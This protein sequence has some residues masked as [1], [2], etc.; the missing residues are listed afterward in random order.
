MP[1]VTTDVLSTPYQLKCAVTGTVNDEHKTTTYCLET[2]HPLTVEYAQ[3]K[4]TIQYPLKS[5][6]KD[7]LR[8][9]PTS[10]VY[11]ERLSGKYG[12]EIWAKLEFENP[13]GCFK[14]RGSQIEVLKAIE[15]GKEAIC[16]ASTGNMAASV[17]AYACYYS[18]P[19]FVFVPEKTTAGKLA[20]A[21]MYNAKVIKVKG[22]YSDC[23]RTCREFADRKNYYLAGDY[24]YRCEGQK[25]FSWELIEQDHGK[26]FDHVLVP[27]GCGTNFGAIWKGLVEC[28]EAGLVKKLPK[29]V[30]VQ[31][32]GC[33]P[34]IE[35]I[36]KGKKIIKEHVYTQAGAVAAA[37]PVDF[38]KVQQGISQSDGLA[39]TVSEE[40]MIS[41][42]KEMA[43]TEGYFTEPACALPLAAIKKYEATFK[44]QKVLLVL[45]GTGLK[46]AGIVEKLALPMPVLPNDLTLIDQFIDSGY[47]NVQND[48]WGK[49]RSGLLDKLHLDAHQVAA[50]HQ[51]VEDIRSRNK[52]LNETEKEI[53]VSLL[54]NERPGVSYPFKIIDYHLNLRK[55]QQVEAFVEMLINGEDVISKGIGV[56]PV[57]AVLEAVKSKTDKI[58]PVEVT[59]FN[60]DV[61]S[62]DTEALVVISFTLKTK[63]GQEWVSRA[64]SPDMIEATLAAFSKG[65]AQ[66][67]N[68]LNS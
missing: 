2:G 14:D 33:S 8:N 11:L 54:F 55:E 52:D 68:R 16:L 43:I 29:M 27:V 26:D 53:L 34:V 4:N 62:E 13:T 36:Q 40:E 60:M 3:V 50:Y 19:C 61:L 10:L 30:A 25:S 32:D 31:P 48:E 37:D 67:L 39:L 9:K 18:V 56:G 5:F 38:V 49:N 6:E 17:A 63:D 66:G 44:D 47:L 58:M 15:L 35:G 7:P 59:N 46:D 45:T 22:D 21:M 64:A 23:E 28:R 65:L 1:T 20:Q 42:L 24:V 12:S 41:A 57:D 51:N